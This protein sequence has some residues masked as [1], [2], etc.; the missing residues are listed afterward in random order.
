MICDRCEAP[1]DG[2][3]A[4]LGQF[5]DPQDFHPLCEDCADKAAE[6]QDTLDAQAEDVWE[7]RQERR[8]IP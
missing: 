6:K 7:A 5:D 8:R 2:A 4:G 1:L 3:V